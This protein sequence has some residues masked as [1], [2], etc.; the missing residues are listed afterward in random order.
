MQNISYYPLSTKRKGRLFYLSF[1]FIAGILIII[2]PLYFKSNVA[3]TVKPIYLV[4]GSFMILGSILMCLPLFYKK[5]FISVNKNGVFY[6]KKLL[7][8]T[9]YILWKEV[10][11]IQIDERYISV[12]SEKKELK[13]YVKD[14]NDYNKKRILEAI[15]SNASEFKNKKV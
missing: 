3:A 5:V 4:W 11:S 14:I 6:K 1:Y 9:K 7:F 2:F 12:D 15:R 13:I 10:K 8:R